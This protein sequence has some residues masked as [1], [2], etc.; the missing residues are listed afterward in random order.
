MTQGHDDKTRGHSRRDVLRYA[1]AGGLAVGSGAWLANMPAWAA[2]YG[3]ISGFM[4]SSQKDPLTQAIAGFE[5]ANAGST[6][7]IEY[8][9]SDQLPPATRVQLNAGT[10]SDMITVWPGGGNALAVRQ[11]VPEGYLQDLTD[12]PWSGDIP[13]VFHPVMLVDGKHYFLSMQISMIGGITN[14]RTWNKLQGVS[15][16]TT[17]SEFV[18]MCQ[19]VKDQGVTPIAVGNGDAWVTQLITYALV[20]STVFGRNPTFAEEHADG[21]HSFID[22]GWK[23]AMEKYVELQDRGFFND[24]V[25][26]TSNQEQIQMVA[27][28]DALMMIMV[29]NQVPGILKAAGHNELWQMPIPGSDNPAELQIPASASSGLGVNA[30]GKN[31]DGAVA[32]LDYMATPDSVA[33]WG[34]ISG[35][36]TMLPGS[37]TSHDHIYKDMMP[38]FRADKTAIYMDNKWPNSRVQQ[39]HMA[40]IQEILNKTATIDDVL[41]RMDEAYAEG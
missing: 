38:L 13:P 14:L 5:S 27:N 31:V 10:A 28:G 25:N 35:L 32:F 19:K 3:D 37:A 24:N 1:G 40:G 34:E 16:P 8:S 30:A 15:Q 41:K 21:K 9:A 22:S 26:G 11:L 36:P 17:W 29:S 4:L 33:A 23:E 12:R 7:A 39:T 20:A 2:S 18:A 6:V